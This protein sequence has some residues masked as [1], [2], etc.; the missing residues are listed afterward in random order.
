[1]AKYLLGDKNSFLEINQVVADAEEFDHPH[2]SVVVLLMQIMMN[3]FSHNLAEVVSNAQKMINICV[4]NGFNQW[5]CAARILLHWAQIHIGRN[6]ITVSMLRNEIELWK[7]FG[8]NLFLPYWLYLLSDAHRH[9]G[10]NIKSRKHYDEA[11]SIEKA[12]GE[13]WAHN[14]FKKSR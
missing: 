10:N 12:T 1:M 13:L 14:L 8:A 9:V 4:K 2:T 7:S 11:L 3:Q 6:Q 5:E